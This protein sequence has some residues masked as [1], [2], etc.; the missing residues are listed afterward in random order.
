MQGIIIYTIGLQGCDEAT[1][2]SISGNSGGQFIM[3][4]DTAMLRSTYEDIQTA[5]TNSYRLSY[6]AEGDKEN[7]KVTVKDN[8][9]GH[10]AAR[11]YSSAKPETQ[12]EKDM[13]ADAEEETDNTKVADFYRQIG[14]SEGGE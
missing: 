12:P 7:R 13:S 3:V 8:S 2:S 4:E 9:N 1:L 6:Q 11:Y 10:E 5:V 14:G